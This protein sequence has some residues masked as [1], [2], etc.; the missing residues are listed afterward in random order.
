MEPLTLGPF[1]VDRDGVLQPRDPATPPALRFSWRGRVCAVRLTGSELQLASV[2]ARVPSTAAMGADR[3]RAFAALAALPRTLP[4]G[5]TLQLLPDHRVR[6][7]AAATLSAPP[8]AT[9]LIAAMVRFALAL[10][11]FLDQF[12]NEGMC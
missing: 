8:T 3:P 6:L 2:A 5:W 10:D 7:E 9:S 11:P 4:A 1:A 12:E